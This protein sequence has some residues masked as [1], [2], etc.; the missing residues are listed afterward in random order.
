MG[1]K[2]YS[3]MNGIDTRPK[4]KKTPKIPYNQMTKEEKL[5]H[6]KNKMQQYDCEKLKL[7][8]AFYLHGNKHLPFEIFCQNAHCIYL[9]HFN[10]HKFCNKDWCKSKRYEN[11][12]IELPPNNELNKKFR[13][14][15]EHSELYDKIYHGILPYL[16]KEALAMCYHPFCTKKNETLNRKATAPAPKDRFFGGS[17]TLNDRLRMVAIV[18]SVGYEEGMS[19]VME[20][21]GI[22]MYDSVK[23]WTRRKDKENNWR[24]IYATKPEIKWKRSKKGKVK[25]LN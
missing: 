18:D 16:T 25:I 4:D 5:H 2:F 9:H 22:K 1:S 8:S 15:V 23:E 20:K 7:L 17:S 13:N 24:K 10:D 21:L 6:T 12:G 14:K 19:R 11:D 3:I